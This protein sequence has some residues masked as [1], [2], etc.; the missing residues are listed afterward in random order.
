MLELSSVVAIAVVCAAICIVGGVSGTL[1][2]LRVRQ[3]RHRVS[4]RKQFLGMQTFPAETLTDL[5][6]EEGSMLRQYG[7]LPYGRPTEWGVLESHESL[8]DDSDTQSQRT[9]KG[10]SLCRSLSGCRRQSKLLRPHRI[11]SLTP[12]T[13][14]IDGPPVSRRG[15][16]PR[17]DVSISA[18]DGALELPAETSPRHTPE[19][20]QGNHDADQ[21]IRPISGPGPSIYQREHL[22]GLFPVMEDRHQ[23]FDLSGARPR[24]TSIIGQTPGAAPDKP[25]PPPPCA[26]PPNRF[27]LSKNDSLRYSSLSLETADSSIMNE[28]RRA[29]VGMDSVF[30]SPALPPCPTF[31]PYSANDVGKSVAL[32]SR[33]PAPFVFPAGSLPVE[34]QRLEPDRTS[35]RRSLTARSPVPSMERTGAPPRRSESLNVRPPRKES[36]PRTDIERIHPLHM[37]GRNPALLPH[38]SQLQRH[39]VHGSQRRENDPFY[40]GVSPGFGRGSTPG[41]SVSPIPESQLAPANGYLKPPLA[42]AMRG[43]NRPRKGHRRQ[44]CVRIAIQPPITFGGTMF[45][46]MVEEPEELDEFDRHASQVSDLSASNIS[47]L[48][49]SVSG[50][51]MSRTGSDQQG[52]V[53]RITEISSDSRPPSYRNSTYL[54]SSKKRK[55]SRDDSIDSVLSTLNTGMDK[56]LPEII[57]TLPPSLG[58]SLT[59]TPSPDKPNP[60]WMAPKYSGSPTTWENAPS[61]GSPRRSAVKGPRSQPARPRR[62]SGRSHLLENG[63]NAT[64]PLIRP[65]SQSLKHGSNRKSTDSVQRAKSTATGSPR[66][67]SQQMNEQEKPATG[68]SFPTE[69]QRYTQPPERPPSRSSSRAGNRIVPIWEDHDRAP[70]CCP[71]KKSAISIISEESGPAE[72]HGESSPRKPEHLKSARPEFSTPVKKTVG[73]GIGAATPGSL[74]DGDGF[75]KE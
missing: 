66:H 35:P 73:L 38:F 57:T 53:S 61:P 15:S 68:G 71:T 75:L 55:H 43:G 23:S 42:S 48:R 37:V 58:D 12:L 62:N 36:L 47:S 24:T 21:S 14:S 1:V 74:Y 32:Y 11:S 30:T 67:H 40:G 59:E 6:R 3:K 17:N 44:N 65:R 5:S 29:S 34:V 45:A 4:S 31:V 64:S 72:L 22:S 49:S 60:V 39:S 16:S 10:H 9:E 41:W 19:R 69:Q 13:E 18:V 25:V 7:Q 26:Y 20:E 8:A 2:W 27:R 33:P 54:A 63:A 46:P 52:D 51:S 28:S 56:T 50:F 70:S